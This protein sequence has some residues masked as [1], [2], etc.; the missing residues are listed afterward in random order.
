[1]PGVSLERSETEQRKFYFEEGLKVALVLFIVLG[2]TARIEQAGVVAGFAAILTGLAECPGSLRERTFDF[3]VFTILGFVPVFVA[4]FIG[5]DPRALIVLLF[6][7]TASFTWMAGYGE[8]VEHIGWVLTIWTTV[9]LG[10]RIWE[11]TPACYLGYACGCL[12][13]GF[14]VIVPAILQGVDVAVATGDSRLISARNQPLV[15]LASYALLK[16]TAVALGGLIGQQYFQLNVFW[17]ALTTILMMPP[18]I[19]IDWE[20]MLHRAVGTVLGAIVGYGLVWFQGTNDLVLMGVE[21]AMAFFLTITIKRKP[22]GLFV[23]FLTVFVV[24]Q[25]GLRG[26]DVAREGGI[27]RIQATIVGIGI[28][29]VA[30]AILVPIF[31]RKDSGADSTRP[32]IQFFFKESN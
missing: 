5:S 31:R 23:F 18:A 28:A 21:V 8:R 13:V 16:A 6:V 3:T 24:A 26:L 19:T 20:R 22:Y 2:I 7:L 10:F 17:V 14:A 4:S 9:S 15:P 29:I 12:M 30:S 1:M 11:S 27:E 32:N 25:L